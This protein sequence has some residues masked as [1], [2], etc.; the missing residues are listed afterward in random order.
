MGLEIAESVGKPDWTYHDLPKM[1]KDNFD[2][3]ISI[4][5]EDNICWITRRN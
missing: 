2:A 1:K 5:G 3:I 4:I